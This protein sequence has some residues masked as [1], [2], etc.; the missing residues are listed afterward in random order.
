[1]AVTRQIHAVS[2]PWS[3]SQIAD[4]FRDALI[5]AGLMTGWHDSF[6]SGGFEHRILEVV[7]DGAKLYGKTYYWFVFSGTEIRWKLCAGWNTTDN[8]PKG[9]S[10]AGGQTFDWPEAATAANSVT[11]YS[12]LV[13]TSEYL[14][15]SSSVNVSI[16]RYTASG[17][18]YFVVRAATAYMVF[19]VD[20][21]SISLRSWYRDGLVGAMH[22]GITEVR[23][24]TNGVR[25]FQRG[26]TK[27]SL[28][29]GGGTDLNSLYPASPVDLS[30]WG[31]QNMST[32][33]GLGRYGGSAP[34]NCNNIPQ[35]YGADMNSGILND[36][37]PVFNSF[38]RSVIYD[39]DLPADF[40]IGALRGGAAN[41]VSIQ[42]TMVVTAGVEEYEVLGFANNG[43][44]GNANHLFLARTVG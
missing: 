33:L 15:L 40:A 11:N 21:A 29:F 3:V 41:T 44:N 20:P 43:A 12:L 34:N 18:S 42:D 22:N 14:T 23:C 24:S 5:G 27:R 39:A 32:A 6:A 30:C 1:M 16:T 13:T 26:R 36:F 28:L 19:T 31:F 25:F 35:W 38:R 7:Y 10:G 37:L 2:A 9:P 8:I 17:V 4:A